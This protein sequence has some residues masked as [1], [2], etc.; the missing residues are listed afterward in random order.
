MHIANAPSSDEP[1]RWDILASKPLN[2]PWCIG[3]TGVF[4]TLRLGSNP[5]GTTK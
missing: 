5:S 2:V 4:D 1:I 3:G